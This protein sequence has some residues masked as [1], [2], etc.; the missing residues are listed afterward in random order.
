LAEETGLHRLNGWGRAADRVLCVAAAV[1]ILLMMLLTTLD[2][3]LRY[4]F[5]RPLVGVYELQEFMLVGV[6]FLALAYVQSSNGHIYVDLL[7]N[8]FS[9]RGQTA[10]RIFS[11][12]VSL[13]IFGLITWQGGLR[14]WTALIT[15]QSREG[16]IS[17]PLWPAK[18]VLTIGVGFFCLRLALDIALEFQKLRSPHPVSTGKMS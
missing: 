8:R 17:Y 6:V 16:L 2:V 13:L 4:A 15:G 10:L 9:E 12:A 11:H 14:A 7:T 3:V 5:N 18:W 1:I